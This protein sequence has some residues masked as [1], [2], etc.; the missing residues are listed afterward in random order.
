MIH[1]VFLLLN[2]WLQTFR[3]VPKTF[4][5]PGEISR[6]SG[7]LVRQIKEIRTLPFTGC[8]TKRVAKDN[9]NVFVSLYML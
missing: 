9:S 3:N 4:P 6:K 7:L 8:E 1:M 2:G 5:D